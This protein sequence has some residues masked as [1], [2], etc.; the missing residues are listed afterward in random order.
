ME[1]ESKSRH[2]SFTHYRVILFVLAFIPQF[3]DPGHP[4]LPQF[5]VLGA[6]LSVFAGMLIVFL[7]RRRWKEAA[8]MVV[9]AAAFF[10]GAFFAA[11]FFT[12]MIFVSLVAPLLA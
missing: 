2:T 3:V 11:F 7:L 5:L 1:E 4:V 6:V 9:L 8:L 12:A 10:A